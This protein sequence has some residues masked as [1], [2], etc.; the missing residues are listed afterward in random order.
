LNIGLAIFLIIIAIA[1]GV[2]YWDRTRKYE[3][4]RDMIANNELTPPAI[5]A[6]IG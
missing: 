6:F 5:N 3:K 2:L 4:L 1:I